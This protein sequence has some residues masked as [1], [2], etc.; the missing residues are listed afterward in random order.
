[1][2]GKGGDQDVTT[3]VIYPAYMV[4]AH[5]DLLAISN[6]L[7]DSAS[8]T[9][10]TDTPYGTFMERYALTDP[11][12]AFF[13]TGYTIA[14]FPT[15]YD[16][17]GKFMAGLDIEVLWNQELTDSAYGTVISEAISAD[18]AYLDDEINNV[19]LPRMET[20]MRDM[21]AVMSSTFIVSRELIEANR[22]KILSKELSDLRMKFAE[23]GH[24]RWETHLKWNETVIRI[25]P[26]LIKFYYGTRMDVDKHE[27]EYNAHNQL[28]PFTILEHKK[29]LVATLAG[30]AAGTQAKVAGPST[31]QKILGGAMFLG[32]MA[33]MASGVGAPLGMAGVTAGMSAMIGGATTT[34]NIL[35]AIPGT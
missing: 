2:G 8:D 32:S 14:S 22:T 16:M 23:L 29:S 21:N 25:Y 11:D 33:L 26:E 28:W 5:K 27:A 7:A 4:D 12:L 35:T 9:M 31:F 13:G 34:G 3:K 6:T 18:A 17:F 20:G 15:L 24:R 19:S 10:M 30:V 1:M